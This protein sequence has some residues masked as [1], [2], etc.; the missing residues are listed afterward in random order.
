MR[1]IFVCLFLIFLLIHCTKK[2]LS[3][4]ALSKTQWDL[5]SIINNATGIR[6]NIPSEIGSEFIDFVDSSGVIGVTTCANTCK[7]YY[8][9]LN[10][11]SIKISGFGCTTIASANTNCITGRD[12]CSL[13]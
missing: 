9:L 4:P 6:T 11:D 1:N 7:G 3:D 5:Q 2:D 8:K 12:I 10:T 13:I